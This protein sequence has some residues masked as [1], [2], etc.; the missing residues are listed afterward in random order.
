MERV[1][2]GKG[3]FSIEMSPEKIQQLN[4]LNKLSLHLGL[5][6]LLVSRRESA[7]DPKEIEE[8]KGDIKIHIE[9]VNRLMSASKP[10]KGDQT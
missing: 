10:P 5:T 3:R 2:L 9:E 6:A 4:R 1:D 8:L 7:V